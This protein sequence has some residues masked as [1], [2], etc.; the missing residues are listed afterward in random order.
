MT[1]EIATWR[2]ISEASRALAKRFDRDKFLKTV[3]KGCIKVGKSKSNPI[4]GNFVAA[5]LREA[6]GHIIH[7]LSPDEDVRAC[8]WLYPSG[9]AR[10]V[11]RVNDRS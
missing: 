2:E 3:F 5:G 7:K 8:V 1:N 11:R 9:E 10:L 6:I 4:R